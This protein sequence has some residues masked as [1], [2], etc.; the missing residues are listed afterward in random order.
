[1]E[2]A[3]IMYFFTAIEIQQSWIAKGTLN[4]LNR[5]KIGK[6]VEDMKCSVDHLKRMGKNQLPTSALQCQ[7]RGRQNIGRP[8]RTKEHQ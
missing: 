5:L 2:A 7:A 8:T 6:T 3:Q 4:I 1:M